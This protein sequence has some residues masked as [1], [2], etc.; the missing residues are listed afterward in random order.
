[1]I[2]F[3]TLPPLA[4]A[5][6]DPARLRVVFPPIR[7]PVSRSSTQKPAPA[8][9]RGRRPT[10]QIVA[11]ACLAAPRCTVRAS[12]IP[13]A[14]ADTCA[15][16]PRFRSLAAFERRPTGRRACCTLSERA[17]IRNPSQQRT[18]SH[19]VA[20]ATRYEAGSPQVRHSDPHRCIAAIPSAICW[21]FDAAI[22]LW[23]SSF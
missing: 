4:S 17:G 3:L 11:H 19:M 21:T 22:G 14:P 15:P 5:G 8:S 1:M 23:Q 20:T 12:Q 7:H 10:S 9:C 2:F 13:I 6:H 18:F 16:T